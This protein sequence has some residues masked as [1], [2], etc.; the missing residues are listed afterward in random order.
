MI[1]AEDL[2]YHHGDDAD[3]TWTETYYL[4]VSVP[5][6]HLYAQVYVV[7]RPT[8]GVMAT[9]VRVHGAVAATEWE[10]LSIDSWSHLPAPER[11]SRIESPHGLRVVAVDPPRDY[12]IDHVG[13]DGTEIHVDWHGIMHPWDCHDPALDPAAGGTEA[14]RLARSSIG[15]GYKGHFDMHGRVTGTLT[16]RGREFRVDAVDRMDH[17]WGPRSDMDI[18]PMNSVWASF[19]EELGIRF[20]GHFD[21][22]AP[23]GSDQRLAHGY[24]LD[25]GE[26]YAL[27][28]LDVV[29]TR[30]GIVPITMDFTAADVRG[31]RFTVSGRPL[32]GGPWH[33]YPPN[34]TWAGMF[35]WRTGEQTGHGCVQENHPM[36]FEIARR[37][38]RWT[39]SPSALTT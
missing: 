21:P 27:A 29:T 14:E 33:S 15:S 30:L 6:E 32:A 13:R 10:L 24:V 19:G 34:V 37:G 4:P 5:E 17:S 20:H 26:V 8:L 22:D 28:D 3:H 36:P 12:R 11:F 7:V 1:T 38:R 25:A 16:V 31:R 2:E 23:T 9:D 18:P 35:G 39:D